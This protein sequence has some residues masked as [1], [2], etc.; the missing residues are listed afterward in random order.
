MAVRIIMTKP[1]HERRSRVAK[2]SLLVAALAAVVAGAAFL[3]LLHGPLPPLGGALIAMSFV[4]FVGALAV[5]LWA[6]VTGRRLRE[7]SG[8][9]GD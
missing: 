4:V 9:E 2:L 1:E 7:G 8:S 3:F 6:L 5:L